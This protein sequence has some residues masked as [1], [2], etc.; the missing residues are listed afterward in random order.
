MRLVTEFHDPLSRARNLAPSSEHFKKLSYQLWVKADNMG[1]QP[2]RDP[3]QQHPCDK[4][5]TRKL[6]QTIANPR[7][8][9][10]PMF[11]CNSKPDLNRLNTQRFYGFLSLPTIEIDT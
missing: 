8:T 11:F 1:G 2:A 10:E 9:S 4:H 7:G 6:S 5:T 3:I